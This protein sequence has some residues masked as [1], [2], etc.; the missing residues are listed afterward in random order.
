VFLVYI[1]I[2][3]YNI[4]NY[5]C[6]L[7]KTKDSENQNCPSSCTGYPNDCSN[8]PTSSSQWIDSEVWIFYQLPISYVAFQ[9]SCKTGYDNILGVCW[10]Q[11]V[12][13]SSLKLSVN[14]NE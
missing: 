9:T 3:Y 7:L 2:T 13:F 11:H 8:C 4:S 6:F 10:T 14:G 5:W 12:L 1:T